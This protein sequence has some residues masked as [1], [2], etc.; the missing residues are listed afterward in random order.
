MPVLD[1]TGLEGPLDYDFS[2]PMGSITAVNT[3]LKKTGLRLEGGKR[4]IRVTSVTSIK[5]SGSK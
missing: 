4:D 2:A 5:I 1:E 3:A